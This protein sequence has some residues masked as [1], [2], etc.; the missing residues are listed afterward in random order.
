MASFHMRIKSGRR[1][2]AAE[3]A[4][5]IARTGKYGRVEGKDDLIAL[6]HGSW[7]TQRL[8]SIVR[9][10]SKEVEVALELAEQLRFVRIERTGD[11]RIIAAL[12][13][14]Y[15]RTPAIDCML[16]STRQQPMIAIAGGNPVN[17]SNWAIKLIR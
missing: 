5:Y 8:E 3:H 12:A 2:T 17:R 13:F 10:I 7:N 4:K 14:A 1:G 15:S 6:E 16:L 11:Y 9:Y